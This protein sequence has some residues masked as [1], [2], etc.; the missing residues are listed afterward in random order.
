MEKLSEGQK[1][2][3]TIEGRVIET[4][5]DHGCTLIRD[6]HGFRHWILPEGEAEVEFL[7]DFRIGTVVSTPQGCLYR[8]TH[9]LHTGDPAW[10]T[11]GRTATIP[12]DDLPRPLRKVT[13][14]EE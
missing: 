12:Y 3:V 8:L 6:A 4:N 1:V 10:E 2:R 14:R 5:S 7:E 13:W 11:F 9:T